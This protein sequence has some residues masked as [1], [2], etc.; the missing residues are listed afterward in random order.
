[1]GQS[2][3]T[4]LVQKP[5]VQTAGG[6]V[7]SQHHLASD[8]GA[9]V[10]AAGGNAVDAAVAA[11]FVVSTVEPW[12]S[13][14]GGGGC[15]LV[16]LARRRA[17]HAID[18]MIV[19]PSRIG[20]ADYP[21]GEG[22][23][24]DLFNWPKV[25]D[26]RN[27]L[28]YPAM[29]V[30]G[31]VA[32]MALALET[33]G[34]WSWSDVLAPSIDSAEAGMEVDW[35]ATLMIASASRELA[36]FPESKRIF[37]PE[38]LPPIAQGN[39]P[40]PTI[41]LG[42][43]SQTL[44]RLAEAGPRDFYEGE[45]ARAIITDIAAN[46]GCLSLDDLMHYDA[47]VQPVPSAR[48]RDSTVHVM[49]GLTAGPSLLRALER[50]ATRLAP[51][52]ASDEIR[53]EA[54]ADCLLATYA[55]RFATMGHAN[56]PAV[57]ACTTHLGVADREGNIVALTQTLLSPFGC[58]VVLP[59]TGIVMNNGIISFDPTPGG[60]NA[61]A[62]SKRPLSNMCP[63]ILECADG[64]RF[65]IGASGGRFIM[66]AVLQLISFLVDLRLNADEAF[67]RPRIDVSSDERV[68]CDDRLARPVIDSLT[69]RHRV[70]VAAHG[71][72]PAL[73]ACPNLV[74]TDTMRGGSVGV[75]YV[76]S[77]RSKVSVA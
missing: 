2:I 53:Y 49:P 59:E 20:P 43:L 45:T 65:G 7:V 64:M 76:M 71:V 63:T 40:S 16:Y 36:A 31:Q 26:D 52:S 62:P 29:T 6:L 51:E 19:A 47:R 55:E 39:A 12:M 9:R 5:A 37:L 44:R 33:F 66:S 1:M 24:A 50:L 61:I 22:Q 68:T 38:G 18:F 70:E 35:Y 23:G 48:Y 32:G 57:G 30:P 3:E 74:A 67:H 72:H 11:S 58:K 14:L 56:E 27:L 13:G 41:R 46:G 60:P 10:L 25:I 21:L 54:Y 69:A 73:F 28:G 75:A 8:A 17:V 77:P 15:M 42:R 4:W 34:T